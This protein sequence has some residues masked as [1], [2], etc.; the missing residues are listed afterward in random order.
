[1]LYN[2]HLFL[3]Y[4]PNIFNLPKYR[5]MPLW[6]DVWGKFSDDSVTVIFQLDHEVGQG[7]ILGSVIKWCGDSRLIVSVRQTK[8]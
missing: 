5:F 7:P 2:I 1:M 6:V 8:M 4:Y 3:H